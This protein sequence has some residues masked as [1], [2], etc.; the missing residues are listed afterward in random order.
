MRKGIRGPCRL[1]NLNATAKL[2]VPT[3]TSSTHQ[4]SLDR[5]ILVVN[6]AIDL[7]IGSPIAVFEFARVAKR[8]LELAAFLLVA[9]LLVSLQLGNLAALG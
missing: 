1:T 3:L 8:Q 5:T 6:I 4:T 7:A 9:I 2:V